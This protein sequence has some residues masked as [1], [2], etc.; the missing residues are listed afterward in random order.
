MGAG[1]TPGVGVAE[2]RDA[3]VQLLGPISQVPASLFFSSASCCRMY[4][5][6][7]SSAKP[8]VL[9]QEPRAQKW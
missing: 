8:T 9:T 4:A 7:T 1:L 2:P 5:R 6:M 3:G